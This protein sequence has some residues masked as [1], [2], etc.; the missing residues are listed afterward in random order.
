MITEDDPY[1]LT[2][3]GERFYMLNSP[4]DDATTFRNSQTLLWDPYLKELMVS[5]GV[6]RSKLGKIYEEPRPDD[7]RY[8]NPLNP[9][10]K[11]LIHH[12]ENMYRLQ[13]LPGPR[14]DEFSDHVLSLIGSSF[15]QKNRS[16]LLTSNQPVSLM[17]LCAHEHFDAMT[18]SLFGDHLFEIEPAITQ[19]LID[20]TEE[21][22]KLLMFPYP[23]FAARKLDTAVQKSLSTILKYIQSTS[24]KKNEAAWFWR[25]ILYEQKVTDL[26][27]ED[28]A[29]IT[30]MLL[31]A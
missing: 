3:N 4:R 13:L 24:E 11:S 17:D 31:W 2:I 6:A 27:D 10:H 29:S 21:A 22:W 15:L 9:K 8:N 7:P 23:K 14:L 12:G 26:D 30:F 28:R 16:G 5:F 19:T 1:S 18:R 25:E 20:F